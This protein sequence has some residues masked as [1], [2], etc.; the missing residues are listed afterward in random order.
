MKISEEQICYSSIM[1]NMYEFI[2]SHRFG[3][4]FVGMDNAHDELWNENSWFVLIIHVDREWIGE[5]EKG[6]EK[7]WRERL[8]RILILTIDY[9]WEVKINVFFFHI[10]FFAFIFLKGVLFCLS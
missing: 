10:N 5:K 4:T 2:E 6:R 8:E 7:V 9:F 3:G 1:W